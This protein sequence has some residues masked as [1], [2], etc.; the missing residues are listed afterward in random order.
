MPDIDEF[1]AELSSKDPVPGGGSVAALE[2]AMGAALISMVCELTANKAAY[3]EVADEVEDIRGAAV[4]S[5]DEAR[6][7]I[8]A[9][10]AA[11]ARVA[12]AMQLPRQTDDAKAARRE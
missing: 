7:L 9:D 1:L 6:R 5:R 3:A 8:E 12:E 10:A 11:F 2:V 4:S